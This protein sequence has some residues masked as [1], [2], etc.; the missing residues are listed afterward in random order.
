MK[1]KHSGYSA[2]EVLSPITSP[3]NFSEPCSTDKV[4]HGQ[5]LEG[6]LEGVS[7]SGKRDSTG[8]VACASEPFLTITAGERMQEGD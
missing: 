5:H 6:T 8:G 3:L 7:L 2:R 1:I 4:A